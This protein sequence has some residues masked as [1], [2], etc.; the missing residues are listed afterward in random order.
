MTDQLRAG[1]VLLGLMTMLLMAFPG[2]DAMPAN[3]LSTPESVD[4]WS[5]DYP[6]AGVLAVKA[7]ADAN[8]AVRLP[9]VH[10]LTR[11][12]RWFRIEQTWNLY[13]GGPARCRRLEVVVDDRVVYRSNDPD[14]DWRAAELGS[15][16]IRPVL[17]TAANK[18]GAANVKGLLRVIGRWAQEDFGADAVTLRAT[19]ADFPTEP[20]PAGVVHP[21]EPGGPAEVAHLIHGSA[22]DWKPRVELP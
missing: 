5:K 7:L 17:E 9:I 4:R 18:P 20:V 19:V 12:E 13:G 21:S 14:L 16:R 6:R 22:P 10:E 2:V 3:M 15:R 1:V 11:F 8:R